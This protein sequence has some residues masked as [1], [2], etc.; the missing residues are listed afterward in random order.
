M[1]KNLLLFCFTIIYQLQ[2][3]FGQAPEGFKIIKTIP[4]TEIKDQGRSGTCWS[5]ATISFLESEALRLGKGQH[6]LSEMFIVRHIYPEKAK[7]YFRMQGHTFFTAGSQCH[8]VLFVL[9]N[10]GLVPE[11]AY[12]QKQD[13]VYGI[14]TEKLDTAAVRFVY[15]TRQQEDDSLPSDWQNNFEKILNKH[16]G[17]PPEKFI[18]NNKEYTPKSYSSDLLG[19]KAENYIEVTSYNHHPFGEFFCL[20]SRFN[21]AL[22]LYYNIPLDDLIKLIDKSLNK[23]YTI[24]FNGDVSEYTFNYDE[25]VAT[26]NEQDIT[27]VKR[28]AAFENG[29]TTVDHI[30]HIVGI[31]E[32]SDGK[33]YYQTKNSWGARNSCGGYVY[34]SEDYVRLKGVSI[35]VHRD[36]LSI[37]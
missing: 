13:P 6:D 10:V 35:L 11:K 7:N 36:M 20:E 1:N 29:T 19:L 4:A 16:L 28:Q 33:K 2:L 17:I 31:A 18:I 37:K 5:F 9:K 12:Q 24:A 22:S 3:S 30:M 23:G 8:D 14:N 34:L 21:W 26:V 25:G 15:K 27:Q 32:G